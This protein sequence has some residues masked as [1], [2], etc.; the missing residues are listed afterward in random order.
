MCVLVATYYHSCICVVVPLSRGKGTPPNAI[1]HIF[2]IADV[3]GTSL[4]DKQI[5]ADVVRSLNTRTAVYLGHGHA[6]QDL[7]VAGVVNE[8]L[9]RPGDDRILDTTLLAWVSLHTHIIPVIILLAS[10]QDTGT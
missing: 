10:N 6:K 2:C 7:R 8:G 5:G 1:F 9:P 4:S 3:G